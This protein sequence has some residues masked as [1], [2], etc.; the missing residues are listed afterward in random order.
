[1][2]TFWLLDETSLFSFS[3]WMSCLIHPG[4]IGWCEKW[5]RD[6]AITTDSNGDV[7]L[8]ASWFKVCGGEF[9]VSVYA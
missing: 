9:L 2:V 8:I 6:F 3:L 5:P 1:M 4:N 7:Y